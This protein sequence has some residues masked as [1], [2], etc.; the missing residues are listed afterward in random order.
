MF[1]WT[2]LLVALLMTS[3]TAAATV[4]AREQAG[5]IS[6]ECSGYVHSDGDADQSQGDSDQAMPHHHGSCHGAA[7]L[8]PVRLVA[9]DLVA[10]CG[11]RLTFGDASTLGRWSPGPDRPPPIA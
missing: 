8:L 9:V 1:R 7:S 3:L 5:A 2:I 4:H 10:S 11:A 6:M